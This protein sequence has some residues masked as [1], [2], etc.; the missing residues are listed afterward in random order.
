MKTQESNSSIL[1]LA[2]GA[3]LERA[4]YELQRMNEEKV[5]GTCR[6]HNWDDDVDYICEN[7]N[8]GNYGDYTMYGD[9]CDKWEEIDYTTLIE[10]IHVMP[11]LLDALDAETARADEAE[12]KSKEILEKWNLQTDVLMCKLKESREDRDY[13]KNR[14]QALERAIISG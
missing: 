13:W 8:S 2:N 1:E 9:S 4:D 14:A 7:H 11:V 10:A 6:W 5:C 12:D 3:I